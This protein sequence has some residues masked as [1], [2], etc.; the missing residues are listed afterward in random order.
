[1]GFAAMDH[2]GVTRHV[3]QEGGLSKNVVKAA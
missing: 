1:M 3:G 2:R